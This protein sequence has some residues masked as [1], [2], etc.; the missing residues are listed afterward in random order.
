MTRDEMHSFMDLVL[1]KVDSPYFEANE[2]D[3]F[4]NF[5]QQNLFNGIV[6]GNGAQT[7][8]GSIKENIG[9]IDGPDN[10]AFN[11]EAISAMVQEL[12]IDSDSS[13]AISYTSINSS[14]PT[15]TSFYHL[16]T[17]L[18]NDTDGKLRSCRY[19][20]IND[21]AATLSN[22]LKMP[23][24]KDP[25]YRNIGSAIHADPK[26]AVSFTLTV[27]RTPKD[28]SATQDSELLVNTHEKIV[29]GALVHAG[30]NLRE[31]EFYQ[32]IKQEST[33]EA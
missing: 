33:T 15:G 30:I 13:G 22:A 21:Y 28:V 6:R 2:K 26:T 19:V 23:T 31:A 11:S 12:T 8:Q 27:Y 10:V 18:R 32:M 1:D 7:P 14:L 3:E 17:V 29:Y 4:I 5:S 24:D 16:S 20:E 9:S 25:I